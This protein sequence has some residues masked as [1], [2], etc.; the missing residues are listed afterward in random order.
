M[1]SSKKFSR[2]LGMLILLLALGACEPWHSAGD[3]PG[4]AESARSGLYDFV[5]VAAKLRGQRIS[6]RITSRRNDICMWAVNLPSEHRANGMAVGVTGLSGVG[7]PLG[8]H[9]PDIPVWS[10]KVR[11]QR[12]EARE[13][14]MDVRETFGAAIE[15][16]DCIFFDAF[17]FDCSAAESFSDALPVERRGLAQGTWIVRNGSFAPAPPGGNS[18]RAR[19]DAVHRPE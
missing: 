3:Q 16:G 11:F 17:Y 6:I 2:R 18:C 14:T 15:S 10:E 8:S 13:F 12:D 7:E 9:G 4:L 19:Y 5:D 1:S